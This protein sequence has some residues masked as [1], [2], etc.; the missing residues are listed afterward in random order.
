MCMLD[1]VLKHLNNW[2][3][4]PDGIHEG[5]FSIEN[6]RIDLSDFLQ[7]GQYF[8]ICGS[9]FNDGVYEYEPEALI[10]E[11]FT[12]TIWALSVPRQ[13]ISLVH[14]IEEYEASDG[15]KPSQYKSESFGGYSYTRNVGADGAPVSWKTA[16]RSRLNAWRKI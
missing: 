15:S 11:T 12:G 6:G 14:D 16:F 2:F 9:V 3:L 5:T 13:L 8:R 10:D 1:D 7:K 4:V